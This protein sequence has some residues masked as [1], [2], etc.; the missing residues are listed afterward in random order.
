MNG[1]IVATI[2]AQC[3]VLSYRFFLSSLKRRERIG[4]S[5]SFTFFLFLFTHSVL[6]FL[7]F[8]MHCEFVAEEIVIDEI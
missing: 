7:A 2:Y 5:L 6:F 4:Q 8:S 1:I 3:L